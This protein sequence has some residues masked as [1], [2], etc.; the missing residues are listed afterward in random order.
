MRDRILI[1]AFAASL[2]F[3]AAPVHPAGPGPQTLAQAATERAASPTRYRSVRIVTPKNAETI[4]DN[5]G[6]VPVEVAL[7]PALD[8]KAGHRLRVSL[9][10]VL[11][12][13]D[14]TSNRLSLQQVDR[15]TH[16]LQVIVIDSDGKALARSATIEFH[17][18][19]ASRLFRGQRATP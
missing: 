10:G 4:H 1:P 15:G 5:A 7:Q 18:W 3:L 13:G 14:W 8:V 2:L 16:T 17:L 6:T 9:D 12:P 11:L 19:Q